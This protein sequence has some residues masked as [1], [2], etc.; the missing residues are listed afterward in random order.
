[1]N[2]KIMVII[3]LDG[4]LQQIRQTKRKINQKIESKIFSKM[5][6]R[7]KKDRNYEEVETWMIHA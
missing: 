1:M 7:E 6:H 3:K 5:Q 2:C 4:Q